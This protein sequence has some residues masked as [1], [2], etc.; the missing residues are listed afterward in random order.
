LDEFAVSVPA[1]A[2]A[3]CDDALLAA[4]PAHS[5]PGSARDARVLTLPSAASPEQ[6]APEPPALEEPTSEETQPAPAT[7]PAGQD[8]PA[9]AA[10]AEEKTRPR[11]RKGRAGV[12]SWDEIVFGARREQ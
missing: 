12:P 9:E 5:D 4:H 3:C 6:P 7:E 8:E 2:F 11:T 10:P 1:P